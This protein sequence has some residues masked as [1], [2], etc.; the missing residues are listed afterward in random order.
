MILTEEQKVKREADRQERAKIRDKEIQEMAEKSH[1]WDCMSGIKLKIPKCKIYSE[2]H[3]KRWMK[4]HDIMEYYRDYAPSYINTPGFSMSCV[5]LELGIKRLD[6]WFVHEIR[7]LE[8]GESKYTRKELINGIRRCPHLHPMI[9][10][11]L[12]FNCKN[13]CDK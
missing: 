8:N 3:I 10:N 6:S 4:K 9:K 11:N 2:K 12:V 13:L 7:K 1:E 5:L